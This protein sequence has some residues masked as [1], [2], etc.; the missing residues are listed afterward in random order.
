M[1]KILGIVF[2]VLGIAL[3]SFGAY[4]TFSGKS[5]NTGGGTAEKETSSDTMFNGVYQ[6]DT[7]TI[8]LYQLDKKTLAY[9]ISYGE[10]GD[11]SVSSRASISSN[12]AEDEMFDESYS[13]TLVNN[14]IEFTTNNAELTSGTYNK[15]SK[16]EEKDYFNDNY[17]N[18]KYFDSKY[19]GEYNFGNAK[20]YMYQVDE[21]EVRVSITKDFSISDLRYDIEENGVLHC[22]HFDD[23]YEITITD[24]GFIF[25]TVKG[26][27]KDYDGEYTKVK[28]LTMNEIIKNVY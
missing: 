26:D 14:A 18:I 20:A 13:F 4:K 6:K 16:Y 9:D 8:K 27:E 12:K 23:E 2:I 24:K 7:T 28:T 19:N 15:V 22:E 17:G 11:N 3:I 10:N 1:R 5:S 25:K 21:K